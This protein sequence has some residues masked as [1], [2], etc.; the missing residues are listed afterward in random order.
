MYSSNA[1]L[2][3]TQEIEIKIR[4]LKQRLDVTDKQLNRECEDEDLNHFGRSITG[5]VEYA[6]E[7]GLTQAEIGNL[8]GNWS[9]AHSTQL[10]LAAAFKLWKSKCKADSLP[11][12]YRSLLKVAL[13][14][15]DGNGAEEICRT[16]RK[17][18][19]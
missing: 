4:S 15:K 8:D 14:L 6:N 9:I 16:C 11:A 10:K 1:L 2:D 19:L 13:K 7:L 17:C 5:Y 3:L 18:K 12:T